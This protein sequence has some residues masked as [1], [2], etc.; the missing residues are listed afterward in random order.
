MP[1]RE[2]V[3]EFIRLMLEHQSLELMPEFYAADAEAQENNDPPRVG[4]EALMEHERQALA[5]G[6]FLRVEA[7]SLLVDGD[8]VA[9]NWVFEFESHGKRLRLDEIAY[10]LWRGDRIVRERYFYDPAQLR[11]PL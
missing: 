3:Q 6:A 8:R 1:T 2:R 4:L 10:Q 5:R 11:K 7:A 9:I